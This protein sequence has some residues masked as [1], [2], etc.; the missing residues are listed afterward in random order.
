[1]KI[2]YFHR[3]SFEESEKRFVEEAND[4]GFELVLIKYKEL[5]LIDTKIYWKGIDLAS[6][7][8]W[9]FRSV[10]T[11]LEW[12]KLLDL[13]ARR[14]KIKVIDDYLIS[15]GPL[16]RA[17]SV[18]GWQ[19]LNAGVNYPKTKYIAKFSELKKELHSMSLKTNQ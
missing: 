17:K 7:D 5:S 10:G 6:F 1:M 12:S 2:A 16:R 18:M 13:Y 3:I 8:G 14:N 15:E 19:L 4:L 11:E 9:Y